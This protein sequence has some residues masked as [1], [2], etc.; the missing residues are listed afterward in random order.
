MDEETPVRE[1]YLFA[2]WYTEKDGFGERVTVDTIITNQWTLYA[3]WQPKN[4][5]FWVQPIDN[6]IY[7]G[8]A[9]K[10]K[11]V[12]YDGEI[13]LQEKKDYT[14]SYK[15]NIRVYNGT[16][17]KKMPTI[18]VK[19]KGNYSG[20][21]T[22]TFDILPQSIEGDS[23]VVDNL[24]V[25]YNAKKMQKP[26][27]T[28]L[29]NDKKIRNKTDYVVSYPEET[30]EG[31]YKEAGIYTIKV[32]GKGNFTGERLVTMTITQENLMSK[33]TISKIAKQSYNEGKEITPVITVKMGKTILIKGTDYDVAYENNR[34]VG[35]ATA[36]ITGKGSYSGVKRIN[37]KIVGENIKTAKVEGL[38]NHYYTGEEIT[39][40]CK[41]YVI[42]SRQK[43]YLTEG[44][45]YEVSYQKNISTGTASVIFTGINKYKGGSLKKTFKI[46]SYDILSDPDKKMTVTVEKEVPYAKG[47]SKPKV[48]LMFGNIQLAEGIDYKV[49]YKNNKGITATAKSVPT[50]TISGKGKFKGTLM[51]ESF[52]I[53]KQDLKKMNITSAD[54]TFQN[55]KNIYKTSVTITDLDG[56]KLGPGKDY[57]KNL[58]YTYSNETKLVDGTVRK[59][60]EAVKAT[61][62]IPANTWITV[63]AKASEN[64][65]YIG[66]I[67]DEYRIVPVDIKGAKVKIDN[68]QYTGQEIILEK[69]EIKV[70]IKGYTLKPEEFEVIEGSYKNNLKKGTASV[71]IKG[72]GNNYGGTKTVNFKIISK[73]IFW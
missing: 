4:E 44:I 41:L 72:T 49:S 43:I 56:K 59:A 7:T 64:G 53:H 42:K 69:S 16:D 45:D 35:T 17:P 40:D 47:G 46:T 62:I 34:E 65:T 20:N 36:V 58:E 23:F 37:F 9:I 14:V 32:T 54:K 26:V 39:Q 73:N 30:K 25:K 67:S 13:L 11:V 6:Q 19:G 18:T 1:G 31:A 3:C 8:K 27:P 48:T 12:V 38:A 55:K 22:I 71:T 61:D 28:V 60:G 63:T 52:V 21:A 15:N 5:N 50:V 66:E 24:A 51:P 10:P 33:A 70:T 2:G 57:N 29:W 68:K